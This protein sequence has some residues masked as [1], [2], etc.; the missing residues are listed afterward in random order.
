LKGKMSR[1]NIEGTINVTYYNLTNV[2]SS[3]DIPVPN[4][5]ESTKKT[6]LIFVWRKIN[7]IR[8]TI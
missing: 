2:S 4:L 7:S 3:I 5:K 1:V 6:K 8:L